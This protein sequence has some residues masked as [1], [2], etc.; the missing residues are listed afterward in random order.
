MNNTITL[1][2]QD[3]INIILASCGA[4][5]T[6]SGAITVIINLV[7]KTKEPEEEQNTRLTRLETRMDDADRKLAIDKKRLDSIE[8]GHEVTQEAL[9]ALLNYQLNPEDKEPLKK[10]KQSLEGYLLRGKDRL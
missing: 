2:P 10:A 5:I 3:I 7:K 4:I 6:L 1:T 8:Y 9:L